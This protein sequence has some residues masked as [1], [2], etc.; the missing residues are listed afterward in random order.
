MRERAPRPEALT[1]RVDLLDRRRRIERPSPLDRLAE[2]E[3]GDQAVR[4]ARGLGGR[5]LVRITIESNDGAG[6]SV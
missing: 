6:I 2:R 4:V 1:E 5:D 3:V